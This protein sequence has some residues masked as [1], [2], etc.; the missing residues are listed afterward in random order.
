MVE[1]KY[2][3][4]VDRESGLLIP[5]VASD[6]NCLVSIDL[7]QTLEPIA[8]EVEFLATYSKPLN[9]VTMLTPLPDTMVDAELVFCE[10]PLR[11]V[12]VEV[13][14]LF[15]FDMAKLQVNG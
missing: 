4:V 2:E 5:S 15:L 13:M 3:P 10:V 11:L 8:C 1:T 14:I 12:M 6:V 9:L 7:L